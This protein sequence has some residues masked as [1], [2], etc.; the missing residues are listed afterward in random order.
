MDFNG[1]DGQGLGMPGL[2]L[3]G[4]DWKGSNGSDRIIKELRGSAR[5]SMAATA[6]NKK[7]RG[8]SERI[9]TDRLGQEGKARYGKV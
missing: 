2:D 8:G 3:S 1:C 6:S 7:N 4:S 9:E 5:H